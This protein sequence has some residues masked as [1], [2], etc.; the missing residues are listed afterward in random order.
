M[1]PAS[2]AY[3]FGAGALVSGRGSLPKTLGYL[4]AAAVLFV[5]ASLIPNWVR[6]RYGQGGIEGR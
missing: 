2:A 5:V 6:R 4:G 1:L 3:R